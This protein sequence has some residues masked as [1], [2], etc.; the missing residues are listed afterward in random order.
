M[1]Y[2]KA[3]HVSVMNDPDDEGVTYSFASVLEA[4]SCHQWALTQGLWYVR[5]W[6]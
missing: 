4:F 1:R 6:K 2:A 5:L 3:W